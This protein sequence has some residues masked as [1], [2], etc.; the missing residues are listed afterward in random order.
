MGRSIVLVVGHSNE[1]AY[2]AKPGIHDGLHGLKVTLSDIATGLPIGDAQL[3]ADKYYFRDLQSFNSATSL[4]D[5]DQIQ[6]GID[7]GA[8]FGETGGYLSRPMV[9]DGVYGYT[10]YGNVSYFGATNV[11]IDDTIFCT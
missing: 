4:Y 11:T 7:V 8:V 10:P 6:E 1:P 5:A 2:G 3:R 9:A